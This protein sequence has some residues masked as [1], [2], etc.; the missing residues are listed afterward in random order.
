MIIKK[1]LLL[2]FCTVSF[3]RSVA[4][5]EFDVQRVWADTAYANALVAVKNDDAPKGYKGIIVKC[6]WTKDGH[7]VT[8]GIAVVKNLAYGETDV[9]QPNGR[10]NGASIDSVSCRISEKY[11]N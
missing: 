4:A 10:L 11:P 6:H 7:A 9:V 8:Q 5:I 2:I 3:A 1:L